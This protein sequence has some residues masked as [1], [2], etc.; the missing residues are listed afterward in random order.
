MKNEEVNWMV[1]SFEHRQKRLN[2]K[3][4]RKGHCETQERQAPTVKAIPEEAP[5]QGTFEIFRE[6]QYTGRF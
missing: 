5:G 1:W 2:R 3:M 4:N 6:M